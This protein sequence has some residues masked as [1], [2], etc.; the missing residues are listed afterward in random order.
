MV[1]LDHDHVI[2][3]ILAKAT[4]PTKNS[5]NHARH[6]YVLKKFILGSSNYF[7]FIIFK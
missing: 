1:S 2:S 4:P 5:S 3:V 6:P 7:F